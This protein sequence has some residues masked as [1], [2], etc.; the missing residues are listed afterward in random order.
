MIKCNVNI[1]A[2]ISRAASVVNG[3]D[4]GS[5]LSFVVKLPVTG[6]DG[7]TKDMEISVSLDGD[8]S[9]ASVFANGRRVN[10][11][12]VLSV[13]RKAGKL[14]FNYRADHVELANSQDGDRIEGEMEFRG[15]ISKKGVEEKKDKKGDTFKVFSAFSTD[16]D[17]DNVEFTWVR[18]LYFNPQGGEEF[19]S[20]NSY[21]DVV[22]DL[23]LGVFKD[24][25]SLDCRVS[26]VKPW[27]LEKK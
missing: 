4:N 12:G 7:S 10:L 27:V 1:C 19:L 22:G 5:F 20:A 25:I 9:K 24:E 11:T 14:Y 18:F 17:G 8:K 15:K 2:V 21:V 23:Q 13:R 16:K 6:R 3:K 26:E